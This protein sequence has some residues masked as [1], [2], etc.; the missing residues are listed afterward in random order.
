M[1]SPIRPGQA[2]DISN[3]GLA[4]LERLQ[5]AEKERL[6]NVISVDSNQLEPNQWL[7]RTGW[8]RHLAGFTF[9]QSKAWVLLDPISESTAKSEKTR[10]LQAHLLV[11]ILKQ[12]ILDSVKAAKRDIVG[13]D[14][15]FFINR[16]ET[17]EPSN[18]KPLYTG[19]STSTIQNYTRVWIQIFTY[20]FKTW[21]L[22]TS[23]RPSYTPS[24]SQQK[25]YKYLIK[26]SYFLVKKIISQENL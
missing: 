15:L 7:N 23:D 6:S 1:S 26:Y 16:K 14:S 18:E 10:L 5:K 11:F 4:Q 13:L 21:D 22:S 20:L 3:I 24:K 25:A 8:A 9:D 17:G 12:V 2:L 19:F